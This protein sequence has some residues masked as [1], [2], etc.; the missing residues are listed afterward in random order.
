MSAPRPR[1]IPVPIPTPAAHRNSDSTSSN[2]PDAADAIQEMLA[3]R[4]AGTRTE[5][6]SLVDT[7]GTA[8]M[9]IHRVKRV[10]A[11]CQT[12]GLQMNKPRHAV[13]EGMGVSWADVTRFLGIKPAFKNAVTLYILAVKTQQHLQIQRSG[14]LS[15][16]NTLLLRQLDYMLIEPLIGENHLEPIAAQTSQLARVPF[17][18][19][20]EGVYA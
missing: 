2:I 10:Q 4:F 20:L 3:I 6:A 14:S 8:Y 9:D 15:V 16:D 13:Y 7:C 17:K 5:L 11:V 1:P 19:R 12:L 18:S